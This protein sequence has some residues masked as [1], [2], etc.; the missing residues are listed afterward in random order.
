MKELTLL[1]TTRTQC[2][3]G[4]SSAA[5][6]NYSIIALIMTKR[7]NR[8]GL[9]KMEKLVYIYQNLKTL[10]RALGD[11]CWCPDLIYDET[12]GELMPTFDDNEVA[13]FWEAAAEANK[14]AAEDLPALVDDEATEDAA[15][16]HPV[17]VM[18]AERVQH[19]R[20][21]R[22]DLGDDAGGTAARLTFTAADG[23]IPEA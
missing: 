23:E 7:R 22:L 20:A 14:A 21:R 5:E 1:A 12:T 3:K 15:T 10:R 2:T 4:S 16:A 9:D 11:P 17:P 19:N 13:A 6:R 18:S 8:L